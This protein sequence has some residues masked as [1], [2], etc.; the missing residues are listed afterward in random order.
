MI[1]DPWPRGPGSS[2]RS[3]TGGPGSSARSA[4]SSHRRGARSR[5]SRR[6][7]RVRQV[8]EMMAG[9]LAIAIVVG[10]GVVA[11]ARLDSGSN[12]SGAAPPSSQA[13]TS[14]PPA[15]WKLKFDASFTG[16]TLD[17][18]LW[19]TCYPWEVSGAGCTNY[20][21]RKEKDWDVAAQDRVSGGVLHIVAQREPTAGLTQEGAP[22]E[23]D[24]RSGMV[25]TYPSFR[26]EYGLIQ[27][28]AKIP[29][30]N[31]LWSALWLAAANE[32]WPPEVDILEHW[33]SDAQ[34]KAYL[35]PTVGVGQGGPVNMPNLSTGWHTFALKWT[36]T[37][38]TW[39]YDGT[40]VL[41]TTTG[42]PH[43]AMYLLMNLADTSTKSYTS[44]TGDTCNGTMAIK[45]VKVWQ[46]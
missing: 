1:I 17:T 24:C 8:V 2:A 9:V 46:S 4:R 21:N 15:S 20:G 36:K 40:Q 26:F 30:S 13:T 38:L 37:E 19:D 43:Q 22:K 33:N 5:R 7:Y 27:I 12:S 35:H 28:T 14:T 45:S 18:K 39:Y 3:E 16:D 6:D 31:G 34:G 29:F 41:S 11:K 25:T 32:Q 23:Y 44:T 42:V 10:L